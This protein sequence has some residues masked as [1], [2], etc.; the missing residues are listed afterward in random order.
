MPARGV[1]SRAWRHRVSSVA[2]FV[3]MPQDVR[4]IIQGHA[5]VKVADSY[6]ETWPL[7]ALREIEK[8]PRYRA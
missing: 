3:A 2:R 5:G 6:G 1:Q 7:V 4:N 8:L